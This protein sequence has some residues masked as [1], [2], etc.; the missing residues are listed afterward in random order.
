MGVVGDVADAGLEREFFAGCEEFAEFEALR[1]LGLEEAF[2]ADCFSDEAIR[3]AALERGG[4]GDARDSTAMFDRAG[5][6]GIDDRRGREGSGGIVDGDV[7]GYALMAGE[8][9][10]TE[11]D[12]LP[13]FAAAGFEGE[14][15]AVAF[16]EEMAEVF[17]VG[18]EA[19]EG[20][21][22]DNFSDV[23]TMDEK[24][25]GA[26]Q[27][28]FAGEI[29]EEFI[30]PTEACAG[31]GGGKDDA[32]VLVFHRREYGGGEGWASSVEGRS[33]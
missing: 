27:D 15:R 29:G 14:A 33:E 2:A 32:E 23:F 22:D 10:E 11:E 7:S 20:G 17:L 31:A 3:A 6:G 25:D 21:D 8:M 9:A 28:G 30:P 1:G 4:F 26:L 19:V 12:G 13:A 5:E 18:I 24:F 16:F